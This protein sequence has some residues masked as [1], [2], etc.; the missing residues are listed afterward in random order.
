M[1]KNRAF[2]GLR[3]YAIILIFLSHFTFMTNKKGTS[4]TVWL[5]ALGVEI[6]I[7]LSGYLLL[8]RHGN[9]YINLREFFFTKIRK[10]YPLHIVTLILAVPFCINRLIAIDIKTY[11][12]LLANIFLVQAWVPSNEFYF[13]YNGVSWYLSMMISFVVLSP[14]VKKVWNVISNKMTLCIISAIVFLQIIICLIVKNWSICH[15]VIYIFPLVRIFDYILGGGI[16]KLVKLNPLRNSGSYV[17]ILI[18]SIFVLCIASAISFSQNSEWFSVCVWVIPAMSIVYILGFNRQDKFIDCIFSNYFITVI[19]D[20]S[21]DIFLIHQLVIRYVDYF[22]PFCNFAK[23]L[24]DVFVTGAGVL[25]W[26]KI[27]K[28]ILIP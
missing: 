26:K 11:V 6:F 7:L 1:E 10:F 16:Q 27:S 24:I 22:L 4:I 8:D 13:G 3:G 2:Q 25:A 9:E 5:G 28:K 15:W 23:F 12:A 21:F 18:I 20:Y 14:I 17:C 19:G